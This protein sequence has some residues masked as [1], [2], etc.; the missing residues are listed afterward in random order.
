MPAA[1]QTC[2][3]S[4]HVKPNDIGRALWRGQ[5]GQRGLRDSLRR[6]GEE[7][8]GGRERKRDVGRLLLFLFRNP[9]KIIVGNN[10][11]IK[12]I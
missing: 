7:R 6:G 11:R 1:T 9:S 8:E 3:D 4:G 10:C 2:Y 12:V 5:R